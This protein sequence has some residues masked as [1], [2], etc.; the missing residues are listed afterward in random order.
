MPVLD[1]TSAER[2]GLEAALTGAREARMWKRLR[3]VL[4][5]GEG[6]SCT[7]VGR[8][9]GVSRKAVHEWVRTFRGSRDPAALADQPR[10]GRLPVLGSTLREVLVRL[11]DEEPPGKH[12]YHAQGWTAP[13]L[14][15]HLRGRLGVEVSESTLRRA[16]HALGYRWKRP[17]F[18]LAR[19]DPEREGKKGGAQAACLG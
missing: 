7:E 12:G 5:V 9:L 1:L 13:L 10:S 11:L 6:V 16:L 18:V 2:V 4:W 14:L 17:R 8:V 15:A 3:G 19:R